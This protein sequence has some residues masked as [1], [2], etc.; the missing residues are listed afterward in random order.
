MMDAFLHFFYWKMALGIIIVVE[1]L[2]N[3]MG[4]HAYISPKWVILA[5]AIL[6]AGSRYVGKQGL[7]FTKLTA[8]VAMALL[9]YNYLVKPLL[10][11]YRNRSPLG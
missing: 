3:T 9:I 11:I 2:K 4:F 5:L 10:D 6:G 7:E 1:I 8:T